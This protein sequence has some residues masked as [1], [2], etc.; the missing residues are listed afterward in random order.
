MKRRKFIILLGGAASWPLAARAQQPAM[1]VIGFITGSSAAASAH[2]AAAFRKGLNQAGY[3]EGQNVTIEY[4][5]LDGRYDRLP[6]LAAEVVGRRVAVIATPGS[7]PASVAAK[8]ATATIP[9]VFSVAEDP[10]KLGLVATLARPGGNAT[11]I[12]FFLNEAVSKRLGL[13]H[14]LVPRA[15]RLA[16]I[17][18]PGNV[19]SAEAVSRDVQKAAGTVG[20]QVQVLNAGTSSEID[21]AFATISREGA[22]ALF[23]APDAFFSSRRVQ[24]ATLA[25][26]S[27]IAAT[28]SNR[29][30][31]EVGGLMSY[32]TNLADVFRQVGVYT[33]QILKGAKPADLPVVQ[34]TKFEFV[35]NLQTARALG[36]DVPPGLLVAADEVIE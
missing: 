27:G 21:A 33:G 16:V 25:A 24:F 20:M 30:Y 5:W 14:D 17:V 11:G 1:P 3:V 10:V 7:T 34:S 32:G 19:L 28:Y 31:A 18:N 15:V 13:L 29:D 2:Y 22:D 26:R 35:I 9:I 23:V 12:N 4:H 36:L 8:T 6:A